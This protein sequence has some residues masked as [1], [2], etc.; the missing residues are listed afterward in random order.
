MSE[1]VAAIGAWLFG[2]VLMLVGIF[3]N[4]LELIGIGALLL[5]SVSA[6]A[7]RKKL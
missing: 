3:D 4:R 2:V 5:R 1:V 7:E 6:E